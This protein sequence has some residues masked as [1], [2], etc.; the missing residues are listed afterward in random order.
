MHKPLD[1]SSK[2][3]LS[4]SLLTRE[5]DLC[6]PDTFPKYL[7]QEYYA[8]KQSYTSFGIVFLGRDIIPQTPILINGYFQQ[9]ITILYAMTGKSVVSTQLFR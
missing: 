8:R 3:V 5:K 1:F 7:P 6:R 2:E 9:N 4:Q